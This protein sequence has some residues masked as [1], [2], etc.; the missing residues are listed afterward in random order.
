MIYLWQELNVETEPN[1]PFCIINQRCATLLN[2]SY[3]FS[4]TLSSSSTA[5]DIAVPSSSASASLS[6]ADFFIFRYERR[7]LTVE[8]TSV[9]NEIEWIVQGKRE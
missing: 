4:T 5:V 7:R 2:Y 8:T 3:L 9:S 1:S 6:F